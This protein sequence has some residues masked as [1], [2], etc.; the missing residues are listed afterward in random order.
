[1]T[2]C[3]AAKIGAAKTSARVED[4]VQLQR[5]ASQGFNKD[6]KSSEMPRL[7]CWVIAHLRAAGPSVDRLTLVSLRPP[8]RKNMSVA[9]G[10][11]AFD[12][13]HEKEDPVMTRDAAWARKTNE[14][15]TS[16]TFKTSSRLSLCRCSAR[17]R[18]AGR[19]VVVVCFGQ[20]LRSHLIGGSPSNPLKTFQPPNQRVSSWNLFLMHRMNRSEFLVE[21]CKTLRESSCTDQSWPCHGDQAIVEQAFQRVQIEFASTPPQR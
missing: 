7:D 17:G 8:A 12:L 10:T 1:M 13:P 4:S 15:P 9:R 5:P 20:S 16:M 14:G 6:L 21:F 18:S 11:N 19:N 3:K 2:E